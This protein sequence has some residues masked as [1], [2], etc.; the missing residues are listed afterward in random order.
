MKHMRKY[1]IKAY[2][3]LE[4]YITT[5]YTKFLGENNKNWRKKL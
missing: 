2:I 1:V 4:K 3:K 5:Q